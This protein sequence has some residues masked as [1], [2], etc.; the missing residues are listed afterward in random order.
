[1]LIFTPLANIGEKCSCRENIK[2]R[3]GNYFLLLIQGRL[4]QMEKAYTVDSNAFFF[5]EELIVIYI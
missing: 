3:L 1:M 4:G 2:R 5:S